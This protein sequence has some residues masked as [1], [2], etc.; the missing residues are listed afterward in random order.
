[1]L[2]L[3]LNSRELD[4]H[5][6]L[7]VDAIESE[8]LA[9]ARDLLPQGNHWTWGE[10]L[11][12]G[13][14]TWVGLDPQTL[15]TPYSELMKMCELLGPRPGEHMVDL[16]AGYGRLGIVLHHCYKDVEFTGL[17]FVPER[18]AEGRRI[19]ERLGY[20]GSLIEADLTKE[21]FE[22]PD[23]EFYFIYDYGKV[24]HIRRTLRQ[25]EEKVNRLQFKVIARGQGVRS[26][27]EN[28]HPWLSQVHRPHHE[29]NFSIY[30]MSL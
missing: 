1:M 11:H 20:G 10:K 14:Q 12:Q 24:H 29:E 19:F 15:Q 9:R 6:G 30:S 26:L 13:N 3:P 7:R 17:E 5:L 8:L 16:G 21:T 4:Q 25:I 22:L 23:A 28:E 18:V 27:I 2:D